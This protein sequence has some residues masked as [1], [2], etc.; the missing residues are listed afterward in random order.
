VKLAILGG[1]FNPVHLGHL[2]LAD[3]AL[4]SLD[5]D[6]V[7]IIPAYRSPFKLSAQ[8]I[9]STASD[10]IM[11]LLAA[12]SGDARLTIDDCEIKREG[13]S[14]TIDTLEDIIGRYQPDGKPGLLIGD[15]LALDFP[16]W[17][18]Y[19]KIL[20]LA[21]V[22]IARRNSARHIEYPFPHT[23]IENDVMNISSHAIRIKIKEGKDWRSLVPSAVRAIIED[24]KLYGLASGAK[25]YSLK[26]Q[27]SGEGV[28]SKPFDWDKDSSLAVIQ[29]VE[30]EARETLT[31]ERF[32]HSRNTA[33]HAYDLC[34]RFGLNPM[35]GYL[36][37]IAHDLA[38]QLDNKQQLK[39]VKNDGKEISD[40]EKSK[41]NLLHG[42]AAVTILRER[43]NI[44]NNEIL[45]AVA[46]HTSGREN[47]GPLA[48]VIY[49]ADKTEVSRNIDSSLRKMCSEE[50]LDNILYAVLKK[51]VHKLK[52]RDL[53]LSADTLRLLEM[54]KDKEH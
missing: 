8:G 51:T 6:R 16:R 12:I 14:Y 21:D 27:L 3:T 48:K 42:R 23:V 25:D 47:M 45:E 31:T 10:R 36:A 54:M 52:S 22:V 32:I 9:G 19:E 33:L 50:D 24:K 28:A 40:L 7:V 39:L 18:H 2:F 17:R 4:S 15:D 5:Y 11:M 44:Q 1:S 29:R 41:P 34:C 13:V 20:Q 38:K 46:A 26:E 53:N 37:G 30:T 35:A 43:F 49:I